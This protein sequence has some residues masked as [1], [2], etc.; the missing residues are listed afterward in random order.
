MCAVLLVTI[1]TRS[2]RAWGTQGH[3][4]VALVATAHLTPVAHRNVSWLLA[5]E[6]LSDVSVWADQYRDDNYQTYYWHFL[7]IPPTAASYDRNRDCPLQPT[8]TA[9][10]TADKWRDCAVDRILYNRER[11]ADVS[12]DRADRAT[13]LKFLVHLVGDVHQPFH[14]L[15]VERGGNGIPVSVFGSEDCGREAAR[16]LPCNLH[17]VWDTSLIAHRSLD[18]RQYLAVLDDKIQRN[19]WQRRP[20]GTASEWAMQ[21]HAL[22]KAALLSPHSRVDEP[23]YASQIPVIDERLALAGLRLAAL[24]NECLPKPP[25]SI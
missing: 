23:Y 4:L 2:L 5:P 24:I 21:S 1:T 16:P 18:D 3:H 15:G 8:V 6:T 13:A 22:A 14:A 19:G 25:P 17:G 11:L 12:L 20:L 7:N 9:G 10:S